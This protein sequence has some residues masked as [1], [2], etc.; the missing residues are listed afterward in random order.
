MWDLVYWGKRQ[1][2]LATVILSRSAIPADQLMRALGLT[3]AQIAEKKAQPGQG[4][5]QASATTLEKLI[6][7]LEEI[8]NKVP[9]PPR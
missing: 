8:S 5:P 4:L 9:W 7:E 3:D 1:E 6:R 2:R